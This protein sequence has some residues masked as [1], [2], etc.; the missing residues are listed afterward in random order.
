MDA[1]DFYQELSA[2]HKS[3]EAEDGPEKDPKSRLV[4][5]EPARAVRIAV[6]DTGVNKAHPAI[7]AGFE[8]E[9]LRPDRCYSWVGENNGDVHDDHGHGTNATSLLLEVA[10]NADIY[11]AKVFIEGDVKVD[12]VENIAKVSENFSNECRF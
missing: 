1:N 11:V 9:R 3:C 8:M 6:L 2:F 4:F 5:T 7:E 12:E 10:P